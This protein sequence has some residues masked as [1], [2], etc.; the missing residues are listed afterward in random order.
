MCPELSERHLP[1]DEFALNCSFQGATRIT[2][3]EEARHRAWKY[4]TLAS[5]HNERKG[6]EGDIGEAIAC[7]AF[8]KSRYTVLERHTV[9]SERF[10]PRHQ[11][12]GLGRDMLALRADEYFVVEAKHW[13]AYPELA[14]RAA[15]TELQ[16]FGGHPERRELEKRIGTMIR[17]AFATQLEWSYKQAQGILHSKYIAFS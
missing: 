3:C 14:I 15:V 7:A 10:K 11:C 9:K 17:G 13:T 4:W 5:S 2:F 6:H 16:R 12:R 8:E 1:A